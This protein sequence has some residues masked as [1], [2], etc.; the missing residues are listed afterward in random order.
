MSDQHVAHDGVQRRILQLPRLGRGGLRHPGLGVNGQRRQGRVRREERDGMRLPHSRGRPQHLAGGDEL[1]QHG[2]PIVGHARG[3]HLSLPLFHGKGRALELRDDLGYPVDARKRRLTGARDVLTIQQEAH[4]G[5][6][7]NGAHRLAGPGEGSAAQAGEHG[8]VG[9]A[10][11]PQAHETPLGGQPFQ[12]LGRKRHADPQ[13]ACGLFA[14]ERPV[15]AREAGRK[16]VQG[17]GQL[18][19]SLGPEGS[20]NAEH[21]AQTRAIV[22]G[23]PPL[24]A[25]D[26][27]GESAMGGFQVRE[28][29]GDFAALGS[30]GNLLHRKRPQLAQKIGHAFRAPRLPTIGRPLQ[31]GHGARQHLCIQHIFHSTG[32]QKLA[33]KRRIHGQ[34]RRLP[35]GM[36]QIALVEVLAQI[37]EHERRRE[38]RRGGRANFAHLDGT[39][40]KTVHHLAQGRQ[41]EHV[42]QTLAQGLQND[43]EILLAPGRLQKLSALETLLP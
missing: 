1:V 4:I 3:Q 17:A 42:L 27:G 5:V 13:G 8:A 33:Q 32:A 6:G 10:V 21:R 41:V 23:S 16:S 14:V 31:L 39:R 11:G 7:G 2:R 28:K 15:G 12:R 30:S 9:P 35:L 19:L 36:G 22:S 26:D 18:S 43:G 37:P 40:G 20:H 38:R 24:L 29:D 34:K 25:A